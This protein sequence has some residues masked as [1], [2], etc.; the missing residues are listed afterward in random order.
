ML[1]KNI[2]PSCYT[3][4]I[5]DFSANL[6]ARQK[7]GNGSIKGDGL[8]AWLAHARTV[9]GFLDKSLKM[10]PIYMWWNQANSFLNIYISSQLRSKGDHS[11]LSCYRWSRAKVCAFTNFLTLEPGHDDKIFF[12]FSWKH[13][14]FSKAKQRWRKQ[15]L[16]HSPTTHY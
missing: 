6:P 1:G 8:S 9:A 10:D 15:T 7:N 11:D 2:E 13:Y 16:W 5:E 4:V 12:K 14:F 3:E